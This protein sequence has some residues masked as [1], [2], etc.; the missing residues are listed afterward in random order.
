MNT[1]YNVTYKTLINGRATWVD[2]YIFGDNRADIL[3]QLD[4]TQMLTAPLIRKAVY[5][6]W[7]CNG[8]TNGGEHKCK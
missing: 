6:E 3:T 1:M 4:F 2:D 7:D 8:W 5:G